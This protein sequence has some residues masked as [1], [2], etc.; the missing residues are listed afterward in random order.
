MPPRLLIVLLLLTSWSGQIDD[1]QV[2]SLVGLR[3]YPVLAAAAGIQG[4]IHLNRHLLDSGSVS[5]CSSVS[6]PALL[7]EQAKQNAEQWRFKRAHTSS[8]YTVNLV[9][10]YEL[11]PATNHKASQPVFSFQAP[12]EV[13]L[14]AESPCIDHGPCS[15]R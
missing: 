3:E 6:G 11:K 8:S 9:Y 12:N 1:W 5:S 2:Q 4:T 15:S 7:S 14:R 10:H 13:Y